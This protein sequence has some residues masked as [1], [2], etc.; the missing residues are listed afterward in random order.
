M[1]AIIDKVV[2]KDI[3]LRT[4]HRLLVIITIIL[5]AMLV[6]S[7]FHLTSTFRRITEASEEHME[8]EKAA[9]ELM[10]ASDLLTESVQRYTINGDIRFLN[11]YFKEA[12]ESKRREEAISKMNADA[13]TAI[14][15]KPLEK[16]LE[17][18][19]KL[20]DQ[21]YYAMK[22]VIEAIDV[23][24]YPDLLKDIKLTDAD[25]AL[26]PKEKMQLAT[27]K[28]MNDEY[29]KQKDLIRY[30][31]QECLKE[32]D[33]ITNNIDNRQMESM[34]SE[35]IVVRVIILL[36]II[37]IL[38]MVWLT[39][40]LG[41][42]PI[43]RATDQIKEDEPISESGANEFRYL[44]QAYNKMYMVY[45]K[46]LEHL[47]FKASH[48]ELTGA[49]NRAGYDLLLSSIDMESTYMLLFDVDDFKDINDNHGHEMGDKALI[50]LVQ[51]FRSC[52]RSDDYICRIGGDEFIV[53]MVHSAENKQHLISNKI[54]QINEELAEGKDG[55]PPFS[56]SVG[57][58]H[59]K[60]ASSPDELF[61]KTDMMLY[62][63]K[64]NGKS[65]FAFYP[66]EDE[67]QALL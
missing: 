7:T 33:N 36:L 39:S 5:S 6:L 65:T 32:I 15:I 11:D 30:H 3:S 58:T 51:V 29:Y 50:R 35:L 34:H 28:V 13:N 48:D 4:I 16:A 12:F 59:G 26:S 53:F 62:K 42:N 44:A 57:I 63:A 17:E 21:E 10:D 27:E 64:R 40:Y 9:L 41:I 66:E 43:L 23:K 24:N 46:S 25:M 31:M 52:F 18:S 38:F 37:S 14:A 22:L 67:N 45:K 56:V 20:M 60:Q 8:L 1:S 49:Y 19:I 61:E 54:R 47:N 55:I 2:K